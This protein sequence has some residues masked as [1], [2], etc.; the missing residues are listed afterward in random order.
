M[1]QAECER[2][3]RRYRLRDTAAGRVFLCKRCGGRVHVPDEAESTGW[4]EL[5]KDEAEAPAVVRPA[6][7]RTRPAD[8]KQRRSRR[9]T[10]PL[11]SPFAVLVLIG[12]G[13]S[14]L[15]VVLAFAVPVTARPVMLAFAVTGGVLGIVGGFWGLARAFQESAFCG[16]CYWFVPGYAL[17]YV[18]SRWDEQKQPFLLS[19]CGLAWLIAALVLLRYGPV[20]DVLGRPGSLGL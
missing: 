19:L 12:A 7:R 9:R 14:V 4:E 5:A 10:E 16:F 1:L 11:L 17:F 6:R 20:W 8:R 2:C 13:L 3:Q 15:L 18:L